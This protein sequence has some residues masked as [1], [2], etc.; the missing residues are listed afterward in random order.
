MALDKET[1]VQ[2]GLI[3]ANA[4]PLTFTISNINEAKVPVGV[5]EA[6]D[7]DTT[8]LLS[9]LDENMRGLAGLLNANYV[10]TTITFRASLNYLLDEVS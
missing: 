7:S 8:Q 1:K 9:D 5:T 2:V 3:D 4:N 6:A 10:D